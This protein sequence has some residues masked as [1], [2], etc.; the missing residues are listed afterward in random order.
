MRPFSSSDLSL[1][2]G[3]R[4][5]ASNVLALRRD[6]FRRSRRTLCRKSYLVGFSRPH[7]SA[8]T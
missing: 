8:E 5:P 6:V 3:Y 2:E 7:V 1:V 4:D